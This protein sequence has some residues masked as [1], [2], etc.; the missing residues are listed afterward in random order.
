MCSVRILAT[1]CVVLSPAG[2]VFLSVLS[3]LLFTESRSVELAADRN[4]PAG[5]SGLVAAGMYAAVLSACTGYFLFQRCNSKPSHVPTIPPSDSS[6]V[7]KTALSQ[8]EKSRLSMSPS[9]SPSVSVQEGESKATDDEE[10]SAPE[11]SR[12]PHMTVDVSASS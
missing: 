6:T 11:S 4:I 1:C 10:I 9:L 7:N 12:N 8:R 5:R 3:I 2:V